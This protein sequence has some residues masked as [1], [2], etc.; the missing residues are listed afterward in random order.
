M[1]ERLPFSATPAS[2]HVSV[3]AHLPA[4]E[5][6]ERVKRLPRSIRVG[7]LGWASPSWKGIV[8]DA[9]SGEA[10]LYQEG[11][12][13]YSRHPMLNTV[14]LEGHF[15]RSYTEA[16]FASFAQQVPE[17]FRFCV[18]AP[19]RFTDPFLRDK[20]GRPVGANHEF[21]N[22]ASIDE[23]V[24]RPL[25]GLG[26]KFGALLVEAG[27]VPV[28]TVDSVDDRNR[29]IA[30]VI[31][32]VASWRDALPEHVIVGI[33]WRNAECLTPRMM[34]ELFE[35]NIIPIMSLHPTMPAALRQM[36]AMGYYYRDRETETGAPAGMPVF[37]GPFIARW[38]LSPSLSRPLLS[39]SSKGRLIAPDIPTR[40]VIAEML[41]RAASEG[42]PAYAL[43]GNRAE[44]LAPGTLEAILKNADAVR[45][46]EVALRPLRTGQLVA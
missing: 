7:T 43:V 41:W 30:S 42:Y 8:Y 10:R 33:E 44:G 29:Y 45:K 23:A 36:K 11:L 16:Q 22:P 27:R 40:H 12:H 35:A 37:R 26:D 15:Y 34:D 14:S 46:K 19:G 31:K 25:S 5:L 18:R 24:E 28:Q 21:L 17:D 38:S 39:P 9:M 4:P 3:K 2:R 20:Q 13:A 6:V 32:R 1:S